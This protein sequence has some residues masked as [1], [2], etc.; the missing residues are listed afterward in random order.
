MPELNVSLPN[1]LYAHV[2]LEFL[3]NLES[4]AGEWSECIVFGMA[5]VGGRAPA[6]HIVLPDGTCYWRVPL[7][8]L[9]SR[10]DVLARE[11]SEL[12][13]WDCF[14][15][16]VVLTQ[17]DYLTGARMAVFLPRG[18]KLEREEGTYLFTID[19]MNNGFSDEPSQH[20]CAHVV[21]L[22]SG[23]WAAQPNNRV[24]VLDASFVR[25]FNAKPSY[26]TNT[27]LW[28]AESPRPVTGGF[29]YEEAPRM[30]HGETDHSHGVRCGLFES[31][32]DWA[33]DWKAVDCQDCINKRA[34]A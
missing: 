9:S 12:C 4:H 2:R 10:P 32:V 11:L 29:F 14:G 31:D 17:F 22:D 21:A 8:A 33:S 7:H 1:H 24:Q 19:W 27:R 30:H 25:P 18:D 6:F 16:N 15:E 26:K 13:R 28:R 20:K 5:S 3:H 34:P 23:L